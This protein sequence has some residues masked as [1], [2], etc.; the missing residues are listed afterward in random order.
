MKNKKVLVTGASGFIG[1]HLT[2][3]LIRLGAEITII[4]KYNS[5]FDNVRLAC[6]WDRIRVIEAD[7]RNLDS[8]AILKNMKFDVIFHLAAYNHVGDSFVHVSE[9]LDSNA[10]GTANLIDSCR[11]YGTFV[12]ISSS[13]IYGAQD[14]VPLHEE[15]APEPISPYSIGK[16]AGELYCRMKY[17]SQKLPIVVLR[18]FNA[19]G[20]F[21]S[22]KAVIPEIII[23]CLR[24]Q[25]IETTPGEQT[26]EF[27]FVGNLVEGIIEAA[28]HP[29]AVGRV[30]NLGCNREIA[31]R[32]LVRYIH[33]RIGSRSELRIGSLPYRPTEIWRMFSDAR[34]AR[35]IL[36]W[37]PRIDFADGMKITVDWYKQYLNVFADPDSGL[38]RLGDYR[39]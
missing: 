14:S 37:E 17:R 16:Y 15:M 33:D 1:S 7:M 26:R 39:Y 11:D 2:Q 28:Q 12:Y 29:D 18:P 25:L 34:K 31:I 22:D 36:G 6:V 38:W 21:Q 24:N 32:D 5:V 35:K 13:E 4:S 23:K 19:F 20:P 27:N 30:I 8:L 3:L 9:S 10:R